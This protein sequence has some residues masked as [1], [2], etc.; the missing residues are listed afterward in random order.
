MGRGV[1]SPGCC[2]GTNTGQSRDREAS[3]AAAMK[4]F[5]PKY[6]SKVTLTGPGDL[7]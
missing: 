2:E 5:H 7:G 4:H 6:T 1:I 3:Q